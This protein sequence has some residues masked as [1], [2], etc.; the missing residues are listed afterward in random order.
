MPS[1][2]DTIDFPE[3]LSLMSRKMKDTDTEEELTEAFKVFDRDGNGFI[4][5]AE[6][7]H[8]MTNLG[9]KLTD[10]EIDEM[11]CEADA[12]VSGQINYEEF[13]KMMMGAGPSSHTHVSSPPP[14]PPAICPAPILPPASAAYPA[15][16]APPLTATLDPLQ[17][18]LLLQAFDGSWQLTSALQEVLKV[19]P[20]LLEAAT[21]IPDNVW[22]TALC[23]AFL[24]SKLAT[25]QEEWTLV[26]A[27]ACAWLQSAG[28]DFE[29]T[30][31]SALEKLP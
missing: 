7:R 16:L 13:V 2:D 5:P 23:I 9:E 20:E 28:Y 29:K 15:A 31:N 30:V 26:A 25:R 19:T 22:A 24:R 14:A 6:L 12:D 3:F 17:P 8:I 10:E 11:I 27:K 1:G 21:E 4:S 18:L